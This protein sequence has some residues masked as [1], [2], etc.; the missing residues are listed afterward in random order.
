M[1]SCWMVERKDGSKVILSEKQYEKYKNVL[2][3]LWGEG[4]IIFIAH[5]FD[6]NICKEKNPTVTEFQL[7]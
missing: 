2:E 7:D 5:Y 3:K 1:E 6:I 4:I